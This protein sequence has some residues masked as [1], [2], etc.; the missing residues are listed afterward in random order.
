MN[1]DDTY[2]PQKDNIIE[3]YINTDDTRLPNDDELGKS[4]F[5]EKLEIGSNIAGSYIVTSAENKAGKQAEIY[6]V[7]KWGKTYIAKIYKN[8]WEP[9]KKLQSFLKEVNHPNIVN[10]IETGFINSNYYEIYDYYPEGTLENKEICSFSFLKNTVIPSINEGLHDLH[11]NGIVHCDIKPS[12]LFLCDEGKRVVIG[13][14]GLSDYLN[15]NGKFIDLIR[16]TPEYAPPVYSLFDTATISTAFDYG[17]LGLVICR[18]ALGYSLLGGMS[19]D[20]IAYAWDRGIEIPSSINIRLRELIEG[21]LKKNEEER[22]GYKEVKRWYEGEFFSGTA[23]RTRLP[24]NNKQKTNNSLIFSKSGDDIIVVESLHQLAVAIKNN[25][26]QAKVIVR[27]R[28][29]TDFAKKIDLELSKKINELAYSYSDDEAVFRLLYLIEN[30]NRIFYKGK[31]YGTLN[32]Y[33]SCLDSLSDD[34]AIEF[35]NSGLFVYYLKIRNADIKAIKKIEQIINS[36]KGNDIL[37]IKSICYSIEKSGTLKNNDVSVN[38]LNELIDVLLTMDMKS[39]ISFIKS[40]EVM[41]WLFSMGLGNKVFKM[42][43]L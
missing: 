1:T 36:S 26:E 37:A 38:S 34:N 5:D 30:S 41:A 33:L 19:I 15:E 10:I 43:E 25:W 42:K 4:S 7:K 22:W 16:G 28:E 11:K 6:H 2:I 27:R 17:A 40:D 31:D 9:S 8:G 12:N 14:L 3:E 32:E 21:L 13:D 18:L 24:R 29:L 35:A 23:R 39:I 20:E